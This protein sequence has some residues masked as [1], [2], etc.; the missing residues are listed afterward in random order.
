MTLSA[1]LGGTATR[2]G[3]SGHQV[4][5]GPA[6][7][8]IVNA[9][10]EAIT[11]AGAGSLGITSLAAGSDQL[12]ATELLA[13]GGRLHAVLPCDGYEGTFE[14]ASRALYRR[15][16]GE[17]TT[18]ERLPFRKP[19]EAAFYAAGRRVVD[20]CQLLLAV[21]DGHPA[22]GLGGTADVVTYA[23]EQGREVRVIWPEGIRR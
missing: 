10:R 15:L 13:A 14:G 2:L 20:L 1:G 8:M 23:H 5:P 4:L 7:E 22:R 12:F 3:V 18:I 11:G 9:L 19:S 21:W 16:L 6:T 17:A